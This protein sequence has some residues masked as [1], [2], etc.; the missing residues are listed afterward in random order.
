MATP[1]SFRPGVTDTGQR[2][3]EQI[4]GNSPALETVLE[5]VE[6]VATTTSTVLI[7]GRN[8]DWQGADCARD[9]HPEPALRTALHQTELR[10]HSSRS[11]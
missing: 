9:S 8:R 2:R 5:K 4:I 10:G 1:V 3:F 6:R 7:R 11:S